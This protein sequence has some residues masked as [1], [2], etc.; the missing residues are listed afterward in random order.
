MPN[1][2]QEG[3]NEGNI[4]GGP[5]RVLVS[6]RSVTTYPE[7]I[8]DVLDLTTYQPQADWYDV[9]HTSEAFANTSGF[10]TTNWVSQQSG[11]INVQVGNWNRR[12]SLTLMEGRNNTVMDL[13]HEAEGRTSNSDGDEV[14]YFYDKS[15]ITEWRVAAISLQESEVAGENMIMD[16]FPFCKRSGADSETSWSRSDPQTHTL[17]MIPFPEPDAPYDA[18]WYRV[19]QT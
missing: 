1:F 2:W 11:I 15:N 13:V 8:S 4:V 17:E 10:D 7:L 6:K 16:V 14:E 19:S 18:S 3:V 5:A 12:I 9:G